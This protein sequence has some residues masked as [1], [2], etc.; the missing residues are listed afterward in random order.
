MRSPPYAC[1]VRRIAPL[2]LVLAFALVAC[3]SGSDEDPTTTVTADI[4]TTTTLEPVDVEER[5]LIASVGGGIRVV[6]GDG[7]PIVA[8]DPEQGDAYR[9]PV[10]TSD[11]GVLAAFTS[12][13]DGHG[14]DAFDPETGGRVWRASTATPPFYILPAPEGAPQATT[15]LRNAA[16]GGGLVAELIDRSG[17]VTGLATVSPFYAS[18]A[19]DG[20]ALAIHREGSA[21]DVRRNGTTETIAAPSGAFQAPVWTDDGIVL[22]RS[23]GDDQVLSVWDGGRFDDILTVEGPARFSAVAGRVA[24]QSIADE[25]SSGVQA[26]LRTQGTPALPGG[27]LVV[28]DLATGDLATV[29]S[30]LTPMF[31]WDPTGNRLLFATFESDASLEFRWN[32]WQDGA[33][34]EGPTWSAQPVWFRDVVPFFDQY[35]QSLSLWS[36]DGSSY[37]YPEIVDAR[38]VVTIQSLDGPEP[39]TIEDAT[40]VSWAPFGR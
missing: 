12:V 3:V 31:Q 2:L 4:D 27:R 18:W 13:T 6:D 16:D 22:L 34:T 17:S 19:P 7:E 9:Q 33:I 25:S 32:V 40:W 30:V 35:V 11:G 28:I 15:S 37:A 8:F 29:S 36:P 1:P 38:P 5:L 23:V 10:W 14:I 39:V 20:S 21:V 26:A 24:I